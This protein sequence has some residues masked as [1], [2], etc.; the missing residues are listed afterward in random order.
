MKTE[1]KILSRSS[2]VVKDHPG[3]FHV[4]SLLDTFD[5]EGP[6]GKH[7]CLVFQVM[8]PSTASMVELLPS[9]LLSP[10]APK[11]RYPTWMVK[12]I[13][14]QTLLGIDCIHQASIVHC[15]LQPGNLLFPIEDLTQIDENLLM[16]QSDA[17]SVRT[18]A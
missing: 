13:L 1:S 16:Q 5:H 2:E 15:D 17:E 14:R 8:G 11:T 18:R 9:N 12:S 3:K 10:T 7:E 6:N 4:V